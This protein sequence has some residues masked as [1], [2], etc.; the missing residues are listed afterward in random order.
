MQSY[1]LVGLGSALGGMCRYQ[2]GLWAVQIFGRGFPSG[3]LIVNMLGSLLIGVMLAWLASGRHQGGDMIRLLVV[4]GFC[5]GF[6]T[7]STFSADVISL[8]SNQ[9]IQRAMIYIFANVVLCCMMTFLGMFMVSGL[10]RS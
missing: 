2:F 1:L 8:L 6:T 3:T 5:G 10:I 7:F 9:Q 4:V